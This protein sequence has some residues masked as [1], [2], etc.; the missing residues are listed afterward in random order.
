MK[1][2]TVSLP[3]ELVDEIKRAAGEGQVS[4]YVARA[5]EE[6]TGRET[7]AEVLAAWEVE[8]PIPEDVK[9]KVATEYEAIFGSKP[10]QRLAG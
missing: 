10:E 1:R 4:A 2:I 7:L 8:D 3:D 5:L 9:R 6:Y